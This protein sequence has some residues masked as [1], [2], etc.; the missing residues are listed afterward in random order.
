MCGTRAVHG[1]LRE[2]KHADS[3]NHEIGANHETRREVLYK[4]GTMPAPRMMAA[5]K[6]SEAT[7]GIE[8]QDLLQV[9]QKQ[10]KCPYQPGADEQLGCIEAR[11]VAVAESHAAASDSRR[12]Y[13]RTRKR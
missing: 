3:Y 10:V 4:S 11:V 5:Q 13:G 8:P 2:P 6:G 1:E 12:G 7:P 9:E